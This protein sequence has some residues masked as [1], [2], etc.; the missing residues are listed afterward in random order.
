MLQGLSEAF[1]AI[2]LHITSEDICHA[3]GRDVIGRTHRRVDAGKV[4]AAGAL[5]QTIPVCRPCCPQPHVPGGKQTAVL[6][7]IRIYTIK[8]ILHNSKLLYMLFKENY[9]LPEHCHC[10]NREVGIA[11]LRKIR[12]ILF[13]DRLALE[14]KA[15]SPMFR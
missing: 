4:C 7:Q 1:E 15:K 13:S 14:I 11:L 12:W 9:L 2:R 6:G 10:I 5:S 3:F 8:I